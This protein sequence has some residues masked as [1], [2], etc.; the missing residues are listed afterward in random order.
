MLWASCVGVLCAAP[1]VAGAD[2]R[3]EV[4]GGVTT[5]RAKAPGRQGEAVAPARAHVAAGMAV[6]PAGAPPQVVAAIA[7]A[8]RIVT[9]PYR[10]G[11]GHRSFEDTGYDCSGSVSYALGGAG[12]LRS[13]LDSRSFARWGARGRGRWITVYTNPSHAYLVIAGMRLDTSGSERMVRRY[14]GQPGTGP[15][16][17]G[18][19]PSA[20][21]VARH[22]VGL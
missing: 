19:R 2:T 21:Y 17:R 20:G 5:K 9:K 13:P 6:A 4:T 3:A 1:A 16:W 7:A 22:P 8:N 14:G 15:R 18:S 11:G 10:Y 12:L